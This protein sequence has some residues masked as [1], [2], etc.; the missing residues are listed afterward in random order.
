MVLH[1]PMLQIIVPANVNRFYAALVPVIKFDILDSEWTTE[2]VFMFN[3]PK[4]RD[5]QTFTLDQM[6]D[7]GYDTHNSVLN[8]GSLWLFSLYYF[9][10]VFIYL[11]YRLVKF[12]S[13]GRIQSNIIE[14]MPNGLFFNEI[15]A[16]TIEGYMEWLISGYLNMDYFVYTYGGDLAGNFTSIICLVFCLVFIPVT[17]GYIIFKPLD[18]YREGKFL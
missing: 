18:K 6:E 2:L 5:F 17:L 1:L 14:N 4:Q 16:L 12:L 9:L 7:I 10:K 8:L 11:V 3:K 15:L 13:K